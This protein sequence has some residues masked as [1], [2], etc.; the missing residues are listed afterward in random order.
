[1]SLLIPLT[2]GRVA[3]ID[4]CD[5]GLTVPYG[6]YCST[7]GYAVG[8]TTINKK[9]VAVY[10]HR[11]LMGFPQS[12]V[13]HINGD[14]LDCRRQNLRACTVQQNSWNNRVSYGQFGLRGIR[15]IAPGSWQVRIKDNS[16]HV[17]LGCYSSLE[18]AIRVYNTEAQRL[19]GEFAVLNEL[20]DQRISEIEKTVRDKVIESRRRASLGKS[21][22]SGYRGVARIGNKWRCFI[23]LDY[24]QIS[25]GRYTTPE[26]AAYVYDQ[27]S[28]QIFGD[29]A[30]TNLL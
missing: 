14:K 13:D 22:T 8:I 23:K 25:L 11:L 17:H 27:A 3:T 5:K 18:E 10:L 26:E 7:N 15:T 29:F 20:S 16:R 12:A 4:E 19:R 6:W 9:Q 24:Q 21:N 1:M 2:R 30:Y 28:L